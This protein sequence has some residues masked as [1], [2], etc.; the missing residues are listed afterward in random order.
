MS[1]GIEKAANLRD[2][3][4][5]LVLFPF[6]CMIWWLYEGMDNK[7]LFDGMT[8]FFTSFF[9]HL[10]SYDY[11]LGVIDPYRGTYS[12]CHM[13]PTAYIMILKWLS[14]YTAE[15]MILKTPI[16]CSFVLT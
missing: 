16:M 2:K 10:K 15:I 13:N 12:S 14:E 3:K 4:F 1:I 7:P 8:A 9:P 5:L 11:N 6:A